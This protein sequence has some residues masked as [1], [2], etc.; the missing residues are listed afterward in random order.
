MIQEY[1]NQEEPGVPP[2]FDAR[3]QP[4]VPEKGVVA[5]ALNA[6]EVAEDFIRKVQPSK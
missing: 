1:S 5:R 3:G 4:A 2:L 6:R